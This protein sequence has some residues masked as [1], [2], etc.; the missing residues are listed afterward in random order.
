MDNTN[1]TQISNN[2]NE[3]N[4]TEQEIYENESDLTEM[5]VDDENKNFKSYKHT[6]V[7]TDGNRQ[8]QYQERTINAIMEL[9]SQE[10]ELMNKIEKDAEGNT[11][12]VEQK[13]KNINKINELAE[14]RISLYTQMNQN[15]VYLN[16]R[17][18]DT[19]NSAMNQKAI[20]DIVEAEL[21]NVKKQMNVY[22]T[23]LTNKL[24]LIEINDYYNKKYTSQTDILK[25][26]SGICL[27]I[28]FLLIVNQKT[29]MPEKITNILIGIIIAVGIIVVVLKLWDVFIRDNQIFDEFDWFLKPNAR[30]DGD[31]DGDKNKDDK[32]YCPPPKGY[33]K[34]KMAPIKDTFVN[35]NIN[36][37]KY[38]PSMNHVKLQ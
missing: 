32:Y 37:F 5:G 21:N 27:I 11:L 36:T 7:P 25:T 4:I 13:Q 8:Q 23:D 14:A 38:E 34:N 6:L 1:L 12:T 20:V 2:V 33:N 17:Y 29:R 9:Q 35:M 31:G 26:I 18:G 30:E 28:V 3:N 24:R 10:K 16:D 22:K 19:R 15:A